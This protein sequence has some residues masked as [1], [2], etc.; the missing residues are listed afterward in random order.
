MMK[1]RKAPQQKKLAL[2]RETL[3][4][5]SLTRAELEA[6]VGGQIVTWNESG[7]EDCIC[8]SGVGC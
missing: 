3:R 6:A 2:G 5:L 1:N 4:A 8:E 7:R